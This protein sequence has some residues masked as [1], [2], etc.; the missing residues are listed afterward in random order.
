MYKNLPG[1]RRAFVCLALFGAATLVLPTPAAAAEGPPLKVAFV[2][3]SPVGNAGWTYQHNMGRLDLERRLGAAVQTTFVENVA[4]GPDAERVMR[5]LAGQGYQL[6]FATSFGYLEPALRVA[7]EYPQVKFEHMGGYKTAA[8]VNTYNARFY[9]GRYL[10]GY[11]AGKMSRSGISGYVA[12]FP[13]PEVVQGINAY[14]LGMRAANPKAQVRVSWLN[15]WFD[16]AREREAAQALVSQGADTLTHHSGSTAIPQLAEE[17]GVMLLGYQS[18]MSHIAPS[19]QLTSV[20]H[21]WGERYA[22]VAADV[23]AG[24]WKPQ[25]Y[26]GGLREGVIKLAPFNKKV[27]AD[28]AFQV[29]DRERAIA[30]GKLHPFAGRIVDQA[31]KVR[32]ASGTMKD[33]MLAQMDYLVEGV[34][35]TIAS[36][37]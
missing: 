16:P 36:K 37:P 27:P 24:R 14:T 18:D 28:V 26:L 22:K 35:G 5:D 17:K 8:N 11:L 4:E 21:V 1:E 30:M 33:A 13:I 31:G 3:V 9:E 15:T 19:V 10:A 34:V 25:P 2:Y 23:Q 7:Q 12:G 6:I 32:Q 20:T 29:R